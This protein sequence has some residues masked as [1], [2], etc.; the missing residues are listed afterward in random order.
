MA[1]ILTR[2]EL[3]ALRHRHEQWAPM[4]EAARREVGP[5][6]PYMD[7]VNKRDAMELRLIATCEELYE[8]IDRLKGGAS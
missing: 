8:E 1:D 7:M 6:D 3:A 2:E 4:V 5:D